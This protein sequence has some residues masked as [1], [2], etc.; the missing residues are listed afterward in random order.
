VRIEFAWYANLKTFCALEQGKG[1]A[2]AGLLTLGLNFNSAFANDT[3]E[4]G[5]SVDLLG[6]KIHL[7]YPSYNFVARFKE[8]NVR[9]FAVLSKNS[10]EITVFAH[11]EDV[12]PYQPLK[13]EAFV[14]L[15]KTLAR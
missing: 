13:T 3:T 12:I 4:F 10:E 11:Q 6:P 8:Q 14:Q 15:Q 9:N 1:L 7:P 5:K 2:L